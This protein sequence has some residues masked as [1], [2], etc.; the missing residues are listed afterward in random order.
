[1]KVTSCVV[2]T[3]SDTAV[4]REGLQ[5]SSKENSTTIIFSSMSEHS[6]PEIET[7]TPSSRVKIG[8]VEFQH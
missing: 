1:M 6:N 2:V 4:Y 7:S 3:H 5:G 8:G